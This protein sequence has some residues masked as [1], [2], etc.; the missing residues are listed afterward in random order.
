MRL[1]CPN[2]DAQY[3]V[4]AAL[5]PAA[6]RDVQCSNC[7]TTWFQETQETIRLTPAERVEPEPAA[8]SAGPSGH[9]LT[10]EAAAFFGHSGP[11]A[12]EDDDYEDEE[13]AFAGVAPPRPAPPP[14]PAV[15]S[16]RSAQEPASGV[17]L[18][19]EAEI[20][21]APAQDREADV[22]GEATPEPEP[23]TAEVREADVAE[24]VT[25]EDDP[26]EDEAASTETPARPE[27]DAAVL[28]ILRA[29]AEREIAARRAEAEGVEAPS[30]P[31]PSRADEG[32]EAVEA[33]T[34]RLRGLDDEE[35]AGEVS[36]RRALLPDIDEIN[37]TL[38]ATSDRA[39]ASRIDEDVPPEVTRKRRSGFRMGF[40]LVMLTVAVLIL[41]YL[42]A[43]M[44][45]AAV[46]GLEPVLA[47]YVDWA[48]GVR[49]SVDGYLERSIS[50]LTDFLVKLSS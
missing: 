35:E 37:S 13:P 7:G 26:E 9:G 8:A 45:G 6:G 19:D 47:G 50:S 29:E 28:G 36:G 34:A 10:R 40:S 14:E 43:P 1:I 16:A 46:P 39:D 3:E 42:F 4:D 49:Q 30:E 23:E 5:I 32:R 18:Y 17:E 21:P 2:C 38:T 31:V 12:P 11:V 44:I 27:L 33:R 25:A 20:A 15:A 22:V 41:L 48:N 24:P